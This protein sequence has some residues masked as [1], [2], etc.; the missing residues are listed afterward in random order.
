MRVAA[1]LL[2]A[3]FVLAAAVQWN[4]PDP[5]IWILGYLLA[6]GLSVAAAFGRVLFLPNL[7]ATAI[8]SIWFLSL[9]ASLLH[10]DSAAFT[11]IQMQAPDHEKPREAIGLALCAGWTAALAWQARRGVRSR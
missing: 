9:A 8:F 1:G 10:A 4:D 7:I 2:G 11:S 3:V 5:V 6:A